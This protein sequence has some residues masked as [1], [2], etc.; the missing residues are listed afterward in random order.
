MKIGSRPIV[1]WARAI[2]ISVGSSFDLNVEYQKMI[3]EILLEITHIEESM[4]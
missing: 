3:F 4:G 2:Q 1:V